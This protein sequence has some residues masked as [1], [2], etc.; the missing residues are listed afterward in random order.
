MKDQGF[1]ASNVSIISA[2]T[3]FFF[4]YNPSSWG[5]GTNWSTSSTVGWWLS[6]VA[7]TFSPECFLKSMH[8]LLRAKSCTSSL[9]RV[10]PA[11]RWTVLPGAGASSG[12]YSL[13]LEK[14]GGCW[15]VSPFISLSSLELFWDF[16]TAFEVRISSVHAL[17]RRYC[18]LDNALKWLRSGQPWAS[19]WLHSGV[20]YCCSRAAYSSSIG[21]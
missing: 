6:V 3:I 2:V 11:V 19:V 17:K 5:F 7:G 10:P 1:S 8:C 15:S 16:S 18:K 4:D 9:E 12:A 21:D 20:D 14:A 13:W